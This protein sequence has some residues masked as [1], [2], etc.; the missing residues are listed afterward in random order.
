MSGYAVIAA[1]ASL[2]VAVYGGAVLAAWL[3]LSREEEE[4]EDGARGEF[5]RRLARGGAV[6][7]P[8]G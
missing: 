7:F 5:A 3:W 2:A 6:A 8:R 1:A 4:D